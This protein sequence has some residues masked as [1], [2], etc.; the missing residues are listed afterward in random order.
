MIELR[1]KA[2]EII[3]KATSKAD[4]KAVDVL[5]DRHRLEIIGVLTKR[6]KNGAYIEQLAKA[7]GLER[8][9]V[10]YHLSLLE[11]AGLVTSEYHI[12]KRAVGKAKGKAARV[13]KINGKCVV[14]AA[15]AAM[16]AGASIFT[17]AAQML[18]TN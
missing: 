13:Y 1:D 4:R 16:R 3:V 8:G 6:L 9:S 17:E 14:D 2:A 10:A 7:T 18:K 12:L 15:A 11:N 5:L